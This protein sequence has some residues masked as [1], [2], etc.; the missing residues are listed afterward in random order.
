MFKHAIGRAAWAGVKMGVLG[1][2]VL[3]ASAAIAPTVQASN[4]VTDGTFTGL[5]TPGSA[6][7]AITGWTQTGTPTDDCVIVGST[8]CNNTAAWGTSYTIATFPGQSP[9]GGN[10]FGDSAGHP[11]TISQTISGL[12]VG[13]QYSIEFYQA[14]FTLTNNS[15]GPVGEQWSVSVGGT[16]VGGSTAMSVPIGGD[17]AWSLQ[18]LTFVANAASEALSFVV[19]TV[20]SAGAASPVSQFAAL[21]GVCVTQGAG[22]TTTYAC[23][24]GSGG[25]TSV[26]EPASIALLGMGI[27][28]LAGLRRHRKV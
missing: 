19:S 23:G 22:S 20:A 12:T 6:G 5:T 11:T 1:F 25:G 24:S 18:N 9:A 21:G 4:L 13:T 28:G 7:T 27:A 2:G 3:A 10:F 14:A 8:W 26:P 17:V 15:T 16:S